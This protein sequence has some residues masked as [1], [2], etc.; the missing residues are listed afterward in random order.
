MPAESEPV[1]AEPEANQAEPEAPAE[2][3]ASETAD[4]ETEAASETPGAVP[5]DDEDLSTG[6]CSE[7]S[8][9][10]SLTVDRETL[11]LDKGRAQVMMDGPV[12]RLELTITPK[13]G[14]PLIKKVFRYSGPQRELLWNPIPRDETEKMEIR[15]YAENNGYSGVKVVPWS[16]TIPHKEVEFDTDQ[17]IIRPSENASLEESLS[18][19]NRAVDEVK[20]KGLGV[21]TLFIAGHT[22]TQ[23][24]E[25]H[26][27]D[28]SR[29]RAQAIASWFMK[30]GLCI[31]V[32]FEGFGE[33]AL[34]K[35][36]AD[37]VDC[38][39]NRRVDYILA[40]EPPMS[41]KGARPAWKFISKGC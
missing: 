26:N 14:G 25:T 36:T 37:N 2:N 33:N 17:A 16:I 40:V 27:L 12:C 29:R 10:L 3:V 13:A 32:A 41:K 31:P 28:L 18:K 39:E 19:I 35:V 23:G 1:A 24:S 15:A 22:D 11:D 21:I 9:K 4:A 30:R 8:A 20:D 7:S 34:K 5:Q 38:Q 6:K